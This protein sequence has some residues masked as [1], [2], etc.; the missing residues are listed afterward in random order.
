MNRREILAGLGGLTA[1][2][3]AMRP[4]IRA[5]AQAKKDVLTFGQSTAILT[6]LSAQG[7]FTGYP[8]GYEASLAFTTGFSTSTPI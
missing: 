8:A 1:A 5:L 6:L 3:L 2:G 4:D 7:S